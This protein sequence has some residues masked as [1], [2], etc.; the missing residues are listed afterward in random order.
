M[1]SKPTTRL[2]H[3]PNLFT[4][5]RQPFLEL[6]DGRSQSFWTVLS[7]EDLHL[8]LFDAS[9]D[10]SAYDWQVIKSNVFE[11]LWLLS[12]I[13]TALEAHFELNVRDCLVIALFVLN[14]PLDLEICK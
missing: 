2:E 14:G 8:K 10:C 5:H 9:I 1:R 4:W 7:K 3:V 11:R 6:A 12:R 13:S